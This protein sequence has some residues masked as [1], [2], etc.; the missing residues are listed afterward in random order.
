M[1]NSERHLIFMALSLILYYVSHD[2]WWMIVVSIE[3]LLVV[4]YKI[5]EVVDPS[6]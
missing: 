4:L 1:Q 3:L 5:K 2:F 6:A